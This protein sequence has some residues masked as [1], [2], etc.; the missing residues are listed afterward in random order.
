M[1]AAVRK[2]VRNGAQQD[3][4]AIGK[5]SPERAD[6]MPGTSIAKSTSALDLL[7]RTLVISGDAVPTVSRSEENEV[8]PQPELDNPF[9]DR[10][11]EEISRRNANQVDDPM[12]DYDPEGESP[13][14]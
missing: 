14:W 12:G 9:T 3:P 1:P 5:G 7:V 6:V 2:W 4:L 8:A 13:H 11:A 10:L